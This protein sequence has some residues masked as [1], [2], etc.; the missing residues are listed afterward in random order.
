[1]TDFSCFLITIL[2][3]DTL[4]YV[5]LKIKTDLIPEGVAEY[6]MEPESRVFFHSR[7]PAHI[8]TMGKIIDVSDRLHDVVIY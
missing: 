4:V 5:A 6:Y 2:Y 3:G 1:M 7:L 8:Q